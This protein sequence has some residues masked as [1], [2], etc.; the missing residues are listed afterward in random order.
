LCLSAFIDADKKQYKHYL[1]A[2]LGETSDG[3]GN[4]ST[5]SE[6]CILNE[7]ALILVDNTLWKGL[8]LSK[9]IKL[10]SSRT[11]FYSHSPHIRRL[12]ISTTSHLQQN[13]MGTLKE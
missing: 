8:V 3:E 10:T 4:I 13:I 11:E 6:E 9:V 7:G 1:Q 5:N 2:I 12:Q